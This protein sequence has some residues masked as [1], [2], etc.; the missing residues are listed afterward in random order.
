MFV[1]YDTCAFTGNVSKIKWDML[2]AV[3]DECSSILHQRTRQYVFQ[4]DSKLNF[5]ELNS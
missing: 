2:V 1:S 3:G 5:D 4:L